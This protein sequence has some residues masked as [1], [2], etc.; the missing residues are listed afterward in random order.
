MTN[1]SDIESSNKNDNKSSNEMMMKQVV[2][3]IA[4]RSHASQAKGCGR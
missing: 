3:V 2:M 1:E 4:K